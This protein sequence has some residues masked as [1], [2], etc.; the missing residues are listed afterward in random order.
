MQGPAPLPWG[1]ETKVPPASA[2]LDAA[3]VIWASAA[4]S[5]L[6]PSAVTHPYQWMFVRCVPWGV[7]SPEGD[8]K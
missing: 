8:L 3:V 5:Y 6:T 2:R 1:K 4:Q 7:L